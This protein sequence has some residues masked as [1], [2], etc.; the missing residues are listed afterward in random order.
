MHA[1]RLAPSNYPI[2][3][4]ES[5]PKLSSQSNL[6]SEGAETVALADRRERAARQTPVVD[7]D[8]VAAALPFGGQLVHFLMVVS[9]LL[10]Y[11]Q[12]LL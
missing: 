12:Q 3:G 10:A 9:L 6:N 11:G 2:C 4:N 7:G 1:S 8:C 5:E